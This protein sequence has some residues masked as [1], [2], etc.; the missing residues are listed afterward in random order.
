MMRA[1]PALVAFLL[2]A[3]AAPAQDDL[4][5][6]GRENWEKPWVPDLAR[7]GGR[8][9]IPVERRI[10]VLLLG[11]GYLAEERKAFE[12][13]VQDWYDRFLTYTPWS[14]FRGAFRVRGLW[15]PGEG[16][17]TPEKKSHYR[18]PATGSGVGDVSARETREAIFAAIEKAGANRSQARG[19]LTHT[20]VVMLVKNEQ[21]RNPSGMSRGVAAPDGKLAV[22]VAFAAYT[23]HEFGHAYGGLRDEYI[24]GIGTKANGR[25]PDRPSIFTVSNVIYT[26]DPKAV[27]W[28]HLAAGGELNP[29]RQSVIGALW[30]GGGA[31]EG[32]WHSEAR[33]LMNGTHENWD[34]AKTRRGVTLRDMQRFCFW[35]E[36]ILV[37]RTLEKTGR[38]GDSADGEALWQRWAA[39]M[40]P[41][42]HTA[43]DVAGR[44]K[45]KNEENRKAKLAEAK[46]YSPL[47]AP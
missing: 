7:P 4:V 46:I 11:D 19:R 44:L 29:D 20:T 2:A 15:T 42:Y 14:Q 28:A 36:E 30:Q 35:C 6:A 22:T 45:A 16:R 25:T 37:A 9:E 26:R 23:H 17:A 13:D 12:K 21:G 5:V 38:L 10:D 41:L 32:A 47:A 40:R 3:S 31:E 34:L 39:E 27:P 18:L 43:F 33:C 1:L 24:L 8:V